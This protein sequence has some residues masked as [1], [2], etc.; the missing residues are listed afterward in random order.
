ML[1]QLFNEPATDRGAPRRDVIVVADQEQLVRQN[2]PRDLI[3]IPPPFMGRGME[4]RIAVVV[5]RKQEVH[6]P[7]GGRDPPAPAGLGGGRDG[8]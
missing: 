8:V 1:G 5:A 4:G 6:R 3:E 7:G 2:L